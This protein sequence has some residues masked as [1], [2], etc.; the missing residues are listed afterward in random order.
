MMKTQLLISGLFLGLSSLMA[1]N[2]P[3]MVV[4]RDDPMSQFRLAPDA[5]VYTTT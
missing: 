1:Q 4:G 5:K 2:L 3:T